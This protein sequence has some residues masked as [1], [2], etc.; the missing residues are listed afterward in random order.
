MC[1]YDITIFSVQPLHTDE[2]N[3]LK[4]YEL[5]TSTYIVFLLL[6]DRSSPFVPFMEIIH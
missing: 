3:F 2:M 4:W 5:S 1:V 6:Y